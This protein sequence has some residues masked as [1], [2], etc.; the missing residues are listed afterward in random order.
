V[1]LPATIPAQEM[2]VQEAID[3]ARAVGALVYKAHP[4]WCGLTWADVAE[5]ENLDG[6]EVWNATCLRHAKPSSEALWDELL[7]A[8]RVLPAIA[9]DDCHHPEPSDFFAGDFCQA[10]SMVRAEEKTV[11]AFMKALAAG[12]Y[13]SS[14]GPAIED[15]RLVEDPEAPSGWRASARFSEA[16]EVWF[17]SNAWT[18]QCYRVPKDELDVTEMAHPVKRAAE[19]VRLMVQDMDG[20]RAWSNPLLVP[21]GAADA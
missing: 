9:T 18:G 8:G 10:W 4:S 2:P 12:R 19:Y 1:N 11:E 21:K 17:V 20:R 3:T 6:I 14:T 7:A 15:F 16:R 5:L 13:Y